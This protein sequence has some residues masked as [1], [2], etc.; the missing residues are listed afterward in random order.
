VKVTEI[1]KRHKLIK[2]KLRKRIL[3]QMPLKSR[4]SLGNILKTYIP[5]NWKI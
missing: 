4:G 5:I 3:Q 1:E 2:L